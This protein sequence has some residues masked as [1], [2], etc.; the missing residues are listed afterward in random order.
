MGLRFSVL[1]VAQ[2]YLEELLTSKPYHYALIS[3][4]S[5]QVRLTMMFSTCVFNSTGCIIDVYSW[6]HCRFVDGESYFDALADALESAEEEIFIT[7][8]W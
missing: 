7:G 4:L 2:H 3:P 8:W 6:L 1:I 5:L